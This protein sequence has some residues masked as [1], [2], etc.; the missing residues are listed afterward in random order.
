MYSR[1]DLLLAGVRAGS[2]P[3]WTRTDRVAQA[4]QFG[5]IERQCGSGGFEIADGGHLPGAQQAK[6]FGLLLVL[7]EAQ[8]ECAQY[9]PDQPRPVS[10]AAVRT[11]REPGI[12][13]HHRNAPGMR[14]EDQIGPQLGFDPEC[15]VGT[16][17]IEKACRPTRQVGG[18]ELMAR[19]R[20]QPGLQQARR[21]D[22]AGRDQDFEVGPRLQQIFDKAQDRGR[23]THAGGMNP[24]QRT[25]RPGPAGNASALAKADRVFLAALAPLRQIQHC[26][27]RQRP[28]HGLI[29]QWQH[30]PS[31]IRRAGPTP[32][33]A[34][35]TGTP[36]PTRR[37]AS[38]TISTILVS[39]RRRAHSSPAS[40]SS[41]ANVIG[42][43]QR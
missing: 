36:C 18:N 15:Q 21:G 7:G 4:Q 2:Q 6:S 14:R 40:S 43:P 25:I 3:H 1:G 34:A 26:Q 31:A 13:Q 39:T 42:S 32:S 9:R 20:R 10:P 38:Q 8:V 24:D 35:G 28:G 16:P 33:V 17:M 5:A 23:F 11:R 30:Q 22:R 37:S 19:A 27:R 12:D 41:S 29:K